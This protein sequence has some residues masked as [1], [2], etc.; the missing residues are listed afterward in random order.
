[1]ATGA[2]FSARLRVLLARPR[3]RQLLQGVG[4]VVHGKLIHFPAIRAT[5]LTRHG[6]RAGRNAALRVGGGVARGLVRPSSNFS[7]P[8]FSGNR[9][10]IVSRRSDQYC[11]QTRTKYLKAFV[12]TMRLPA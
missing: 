8:S 12:P 1:M 10:T 11:H 6:T 4:Y 2:V 7:P 5:R 9:S 3:A